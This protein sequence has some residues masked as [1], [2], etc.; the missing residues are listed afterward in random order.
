MY[1]PT[2]D[3]T[4]CG[5]DAGY[6]TADGTYSYH[7]ALN[8]HCSITK[9]YTSKLE[10]CD[11]WCHNNPFKISTIYVKCQEQYDTLTCSMRHFCG[12]TCNLRHLQIV[13][14]L[15]IIW[16]VYIQFETSAYR[17]RSACI[18]W[19]SHKQPDTLACSLSHP[20]AVWDTYRVSG[21]HT[22]WNSYIQFKVIHRF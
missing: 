9:L 4:L 5:Q 7:S 8:G 3:S 10:T 6:V 13:R 18:V 14:H 11:S 12:I 17:L 21:A 15:C 2:C 22:A 16:G 19:G 20:G 1:N